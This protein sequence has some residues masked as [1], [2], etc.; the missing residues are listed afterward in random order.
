VVGTLTLGVEFGI[1]APG[2]EI[3]FV[4]E[5]IGMCMLAAEAGMQVAWVGMQVVEVVVLAMV[6]TW[7]ENTQIDWNV[8]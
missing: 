2:M 4:A 7:S 5:W 6:S 1:L 8:G 3:R